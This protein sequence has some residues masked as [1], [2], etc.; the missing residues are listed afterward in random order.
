MQPWIG[1]LRD[2][3][4]DTLDGLYDEGGEGEAPEHGE[5]LPSLRLLR[6]HSDV[7]LHARGPNSPSPGT[8]GACVQ[9]LWRY[10][11]KRLM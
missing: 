8:S 1:R 2:S 3:G 5:A 7:K 6:G 4:A 11:P 9:S 10:R